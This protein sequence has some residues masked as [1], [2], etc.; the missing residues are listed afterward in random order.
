MDLVNASSYLS[1]LFVPK[2]EKSEEYVYGWKNKN[3]VLN[4]EHKSN[5]ESTVIWR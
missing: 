5:P 4:C 3:V 1:V 2:F